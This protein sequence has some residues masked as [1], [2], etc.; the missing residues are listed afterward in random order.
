MRKRYDARLLLAHLG[1]LDRLASNRKTE[2][3]AGE[4]FEQVEALVE[5]PEIVFQDAASEEDDACEP[6]A[7]ISAQDTVPSVSD[8]PE[9][10]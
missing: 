10:R 2:E 4:F 3:L 8:E 1:R 5:E 7:E 6:D 9:L